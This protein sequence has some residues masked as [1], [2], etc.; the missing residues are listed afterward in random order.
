[1]PHAT[2][3]IGVSIAA[4]RLTLCLPNIAAALVG[5]QIRPVDSVARVLVVHRR[6]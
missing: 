3:V 4:D 1:M 5:S 2:S 6:R